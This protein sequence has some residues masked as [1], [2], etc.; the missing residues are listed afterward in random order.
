MEIRT[1]AE[2]QA[3][4]RSSLFVAAPVILSVCPFVAGCG[5]PG[6]PVPPMPPIPVAVSDLSARQVG[7]SVL[8]TFT[9]PNK[10]TLGER[11]TLVPTMEVL[12]G[13]L[14][15]NGRPEAKSFRVVDTVPGAV[16]S[17]YMQQGKAEFPEPI[18]AEEL[19]SNPVE[20]VAYRIRTRVSERKVSA[21]SNEVTVN[22]HPVPEAIG[23][24]E[25]KVTEDGIQLKWRVPS[26]NSL[27]EPI[28]GVKEYHVYRGELE[29]EPGEGA[30][31]D[32]RQ[33]KWR[34]PLL[35]LATTVVP[36][37]EDRGF[38]YGKTYAY[39]VRSAVAAGGELLESG[40][41]K[42]AIVTPK[43]I[44]P[45]AAPQSVVAAVLP[46]SGAGSYVVDLSW[47]INVETDLAGY[48]VY[49]SESEGA[50]GELLTRE[51]LLTPAYRDT[52]VEGG[53]SYWYT[54]RAVDRAGNESGPSQT[55]AVEIAQPFR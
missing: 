28:S 17:G 12:R 31:K 39:V 13:S 24:V 34:L 25:A 14:G 9:P 54:V 6:E 15:E 38:D 7:N 42:T 55:V 35:P 50:S 2:S 21:D 32:L 36:E 45:P 8:L 52:S 5:A 53:H 44:F 26:S 43:D 40:D 11:L 46:G 30:T 51:L 41:S 1:G 19:R 18:S 10:S 37:Y 47:A 20:S 22:L 48:R 3:P 23:A 49:R 4:R 29:A 33:A 27:G 16:L